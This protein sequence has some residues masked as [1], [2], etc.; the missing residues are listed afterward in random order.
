MAI[1]HQNSSFSSYY[2]ALEKLLDS[3]NWELVVAKNTKPLK[4]AHQLSKIINQILRQ[5]DW[6]ILFLDEEAHPSMPIWE[7]FEGGISLAIN[8]DHHIG[9]LENRTYLERPEPT[10]HTVGHITTKLFFKCDSHQK[11]DKKILSL[12]YYVVAVILALMICYLFHNN[13]RINRHK[14]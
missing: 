7:E 11:K 12:G 13:H 14:K 10:Q 8:H 3:G 1:R 4:S 6:T 9:S 2:S 5:P